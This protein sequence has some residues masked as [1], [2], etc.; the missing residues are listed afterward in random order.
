MLELVSGLRLPVIH[1][2]DLIGLK[3]QAAVNDPSRH[4]RDWSD[5]YLMVENAARQATPLDW[6]LL[7]DYLAL[8]DLT[9]ELSNLKQLYGQTH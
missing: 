1:I 3:V 2:E 7:A 8:F 4:R 6:D 9:P 5:I